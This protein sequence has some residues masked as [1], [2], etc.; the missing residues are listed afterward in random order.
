M[1]AA[2]PVVLDLDHSVGPLPGECR[3][4]LHDLQ[5]AVRFGCGLPRFRRFARLLDARMPAFGAHG[6]V[7]MGSGDFHHLSGPLVA[8]CI[9]ARAFTAQRPLRIV[10]LD[11]HPDNM[12]FPFGIHC[13]SWVRH[14]ALLPQVS[15]VH[16]VG[17]TSGDI[18]RGHAWE[19]YL[20]PLRTGKLCYWSTGVDTRWSRWLG[21]GAAFRS[22]PDGDALVQALCATLAADP[23][24]TYLSID[25]DAFAPDVVRTNWD[26]GVL[27]ADHAEAVI[28]ALRGQMAGSDVTGE[29]SSYRY[30]TAWKRW[31]SAGDGQQTEIAPDTLRQWQAGQ[32]AFNQRLLEKLRSA[33]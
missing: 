22:F 24:P 25:K 15:Q 31:L 5:E 28:G 27:R 13:G 16:V 14:A 32:D 33:G 4:P 3:L 2:A 26:Q 12:R 7:F 21:L 29:V 10:V 30:A 19:N 17:I 23:Q 9:A 20:Q 1:N 18:G 6:T 11:N 8:R